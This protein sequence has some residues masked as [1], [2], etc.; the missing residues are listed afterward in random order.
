MGAA[1]LSVAG[2]RK[3]YVDNTVLDGVDL[4]LAPGEVVALLGP[5]GAGKS[6]LIGCVCGTVIPDEGRVAIAGH[7]IRAQPIE[8]RRALR[9][10]P[11]EVDVPA[12]L[13]G[14]ELLS[15]HAEVFGEPAAMARAEALADLGPALDLLASTYSVGMRRRLAMACLV[16]GDGALLVLDEPFAGIDAAGR[17]RALA[18]LVEQRDRG[19]AILM[20]AHAQ[21]QWALDAL[22]ARPVALGSPRA[23]S[24]ADTD[25][26]GS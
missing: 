16:P 24:E 19:A 26:A 4:R 9:Y 14:R 21:D 25:E 18:W 23:T 5:N 10:L 6:T 2:L 17:A 7:D 20:A 15:F 8:A 12:G 22:G 11:Q 3:R 1:P 13:T